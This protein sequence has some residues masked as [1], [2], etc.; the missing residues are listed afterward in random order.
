MII[1]D[2]YTMGGRKLFQ[3]LK[4][5][6]WLSLVKLLKLTDGH[7]LGLTCDLHYFPISSEMDD[8]NW[9]VDSMSP[10]L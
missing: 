7:G 3:L 1:F 8:I 5:V 2:V 9:F 4:F 6:S 10:G